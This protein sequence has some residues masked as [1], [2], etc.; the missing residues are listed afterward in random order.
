MP[1]R[2]DVVKKQQDVGIFVSQRKSGRDSILTIEG[3]DYVKKAKPI[4]IGAVNNNEVETPD[5]VIQELNE[6]FGVMFDPCPFVGKG[7]Q[8]DFD[9]LAI[10]WK[11]IN[12]VNPPY[13]TVG[14]WFEKAVKEWQTRGCVSVFLVPVRAGT[15]Y[16]L[17][18]WDRAYSVRFIRGKIMFK[19]YTKAMPHHLAIIVFGNRYPQASI[20]V[21]HLSPVEYSERTSAVVNMKNLCAVI[22]G[23]TKLFDR[24][25][26]GRYKLR[27]PPLMAK[28]WQMVCEYTE[29]VFN[30]QEP[31][32]VRL[33]M[34]LYMSLLWLDYESGDT[35][36]FGPTPDSN[37]KLQTLPELLRCARHRF[38]QEP[39]KIQQVV[40]SSVFGQSKPLDL[41]KV[42][43]DLLYSFYVAYRFCIIQHQLNA[44]RL[45]YQKQSQ[46]RSYLF[47]TA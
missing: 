39:N 16:W 2:Q 14:L 35:F 30:T 36:D 4:H 12:Y 19:G 9:G 17:D 25:S 42:E 44:L 45:P 22:H 34:P 33:L 1:K 38:L 47:N 46:D 26:N 23:P 8:P 15:K 20:E 21:R 41:S 7:L 24:T 18:A 13:N 43:S 29:T 32:I 37:N 40:A 28:S 11:P 3:K 5:N 6:E 27:D 10:D 31:F